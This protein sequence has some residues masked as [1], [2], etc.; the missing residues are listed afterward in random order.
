MAD[1][2]VPYC[3]GPSAIHITRN[4]VRV[5][6]RSG[7]VR[8]EKAMS[9]GDLERTGQ[10]IKLALERYARGEQDVIVD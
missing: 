2:L 7:D 4:V 1:Q 10:R 3:G 8:I 9:V 5:V 6:D